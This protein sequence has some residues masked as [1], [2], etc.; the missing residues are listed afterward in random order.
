MVGQ[1]LVT[2]QTG[3]TGVPVY[4]VMVAEACDIKRESYLAILMDRESNG[5]VIVASPQ[6]GMNIEEVAE[7]HPDQVL[8]SPVDINTGVTDEQA[9]KIAKFLGFQDKLIPTAADQIKRLYKIFLDVDATQIEINPFAETMDG[10]SM[11]SLCI[12]MF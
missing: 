1:R 12:A 3:P 9:K 7:K 8:K 11:F 5:P 10:R 6:G 4:K 2:Q